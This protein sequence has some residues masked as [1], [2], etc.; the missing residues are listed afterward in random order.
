KK[1]DPQ[2]Q[3]RT[4]SR[5][6]TTIIV[7]ICADD[8]STPPAVIFKGNVYQVKWKQDNPANASIGYSKKGWMD[9]EIGIEWIKRFDKNTKDKADGQDQLLLVDGHN[10]HYTRGF[11]QYAHTHQIHILCYPTHG[12]HVYQGLDVMVFAVLKHCWSEERV[13]WEREH[14]EGI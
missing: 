5:E 6:N 4:G 8:T 7:M 11:L 13:K 14:G 2:Y 9:G 12:T 10:S 3:Q 1:N